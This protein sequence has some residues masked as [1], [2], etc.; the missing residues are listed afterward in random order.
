MLC[1]WFYLKVNEMLYEETLCL[2]IL[3]LFAGKNPKKLQIE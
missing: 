2:I 3:E 1:A